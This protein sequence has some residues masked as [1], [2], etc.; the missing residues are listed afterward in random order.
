MSHLV[1]YLSGMLS[2]QSYSHAHKAEDAHQAYSD[3]FTQHIASCSALV[4]AAN[5][6]CE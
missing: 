6:N 1:Q 3:V 4:T 5:L 2:L